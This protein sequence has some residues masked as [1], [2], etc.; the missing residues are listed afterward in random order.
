[1][2]ERAGLENRCTASRYRGFESHLLRC[3]EQGW[4]FSYRRPIEARQTG[5]QTDSPIAKSP[6]KSKT[7][8]CLQRL[9]HRLPRHV[10]V[11]KARRRPLAILAESWQ[12]AAQER[13]FRTLPS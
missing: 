10:R 13:A 4:P 9:R 8:V 6:G 2:V 1:V 7:Q 5:L 3:D 11:P 12:R